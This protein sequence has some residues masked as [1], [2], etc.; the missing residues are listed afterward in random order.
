MDFFILLKFHRLTAL[1]GQINI[2]KAAAIFFN[3]LLV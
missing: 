1:T 3:N 2:Q